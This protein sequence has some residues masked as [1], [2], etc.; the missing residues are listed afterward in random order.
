MQLRDLRNS[1]VVLT[2]ASSGIGRATAYEFA[3]CGAALFLAGRDRHALHDVAETCHRLGGQA[4]IVV[5][6]VSNSDDMAR[7][8]ESAVDLAG[9]IDIWVNNAGVGALGPFEEVP[10]DVHEQVVQTDLLGGL[11]GAHAVL[12]HFK[13]QGRGILINNISL[14]GWAPQ[15]YAASYSAAKFGLR[16]FA[17]SL[18]G[19]LRQ[20]PELHVC[21]VYPSVM[22][23]PGFRDGGNFTGRA[24]KPV[25][26]VYDPRRTAKAIVGLARRPRHSAYVGLPAI[27]SLLA[28]FVPGYSILNAALV[29]GS[30]RRARPIPRSSG[31]LFQPPGG[32]RRIDGGYRSS[33]LRQGVLVAASATAALMVGRWLAGKR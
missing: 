5:A 31:N 26:P 12:P 15:P 21:N 22:D 4:R 10:L 32:E 23:T 20:W 33:R 18:R 27:L 28:R 2:G 25:P 8:A 30:V 13:R 7:L 11:R 29:D 3:R 9:R 16:A 19:E 14:G 17:D 6:D 1:V 24:I